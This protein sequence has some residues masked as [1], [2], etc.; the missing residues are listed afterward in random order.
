MR[1]SKRYE[2]RKCVKEISIL[3][4]KYFKINLTNTM[5]VEICLTLENELINIDDRYVI[6]LQ[7]CIYVLLQHLCANNG[8]CRQN[9]MCANN[10]FYFVDKI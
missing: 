10:E 7:T 5:V 3:K 2:N 9:Y 1:G 8:F 4:Y 6:C